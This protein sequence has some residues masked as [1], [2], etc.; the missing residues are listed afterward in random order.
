MTGPKKQQGVAII[1]AMLVV[2]LATILA[3]EMAFEG[4][5]NMRRAAALRLTDQAQSFAVGAEDWASEILTLDLTESGDTSNT[6]NLGEYWALDIPPLPLT[7]ADG[8]EIGQMLGSIDDMQAR[9][10]INNLVGDSGAVD[11][12]AKAQFECMLG[13]LN[14]DVALAGN[15]ADWIDADATPEFPQ[16]AEDDFYTG[17][18]PPYLT[19]NTPIT[20]TSELLAVD[21]IDREIYA[22][23]DP[24]IVALPVRTL[25]NVNTVERLHDDDPLPTLQCMEPNL[26]QGDAEN[27]ID[28]RPPEGYETMNDFLPVSGISDSNTAN[29]VAQLESSYFRAN[30]RVAIGTFQ[31]SMYSLLY[32]GPNGDVSALLRTY[33]AL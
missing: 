15:V 17:L 24:Y 7:D 32:R 4:H 27:I 21:G 10:N 3:A 1:V 26:T 6:D 31:L 14:L 8:Q 30:I 5:L 12:V 22:I 20:S 11:P 33:G 18:E 23:L 13:V 25:I 2:A 28:S 9:F 29:A 19:A 16:G